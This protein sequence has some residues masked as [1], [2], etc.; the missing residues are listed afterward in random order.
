LV[1]LNEP[2]AHAQKLNQAMLEKRVDTLSRMQQAQ[3]ALVKNLN[4]LREELVVIDDRIMRTKTR[5]EQT[6]AAIVPDT[7]SVLA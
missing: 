1:K 6:A 2:I 7:S 3:Q 4:A 5:C